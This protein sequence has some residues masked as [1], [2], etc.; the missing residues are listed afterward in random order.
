MLLLGMNSVWAFLI[1][2]GKHENLAIDDGAT[3]KSLLPTS[4]EIKRAHTL[5]YSITISSLLSCEF[6]AY[7]KTCL[8]VFEYFFYLV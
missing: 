7:K 8:C 1:L 3:M 5:Y 6:H 4:K 2:L